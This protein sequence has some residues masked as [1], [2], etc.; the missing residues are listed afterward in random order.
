MGVGNKQEQKNNLRISA[1]ESLTFLIRIMW[2]KKSSPK[3]TQAKTETAVHTIYTYWTR[4]KFSNILNDAQLP[5]QDYYY[6]LNRRYTTTAANGG[7]ENPF[8]SLSMISD[9]IPLL[10]TKKRTITAIPTPASITS[11]SAEE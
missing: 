4:N 3:G 8:P 2:K 6:N 7:R 11:W 1:T 9:S 5:Y 10:L